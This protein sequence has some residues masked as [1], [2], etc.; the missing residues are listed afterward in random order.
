MVYV[1]FIKINATWIICNTLRAFSHICYRFII[2]HNRIFKLFRKSCLFYWQVLFFSVTK[3]S[4]IKK[5]WS[6]IWSSLKKY[7]SPILSS[8]RIFSDDIHKY[9]RPLKWPHT[10]LPVIIITPCVIIVLEHTLSD[11]R[12]LGD[13]LMQ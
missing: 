7:I 13:G 2:I 6:N 5:Q 9:S 12:Y 11:P 1:H 3:D 8:Y 10:I 4:A